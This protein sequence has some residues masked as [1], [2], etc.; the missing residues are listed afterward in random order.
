MSDQNSSD[1]QT[2]GN[3]NQL[4]VRS[5]PNVLAQPVQRIPRATTVS[6][7]RQDADLGPAFVLW[8][9]RQWWKITIPTGLVLAG[10]TAVV[11]MYF[12][13]PEYRASALIDIEQTVPFIAFDKGKVSG[14]RGNVQYIQTQIEL[15]RSAVVL[16]PVLSKPEIAKLEE[17][18]EQV[19]PLEYL[20]KQITVAQVGKSQLYSV[21]YVCPSAQAAADITNAV[22]T[23]YLEL[24]TDEEYRLSQRVIALLEEERLRRS[25]EVERLRDRVLELAKEVTGKDPFGGGIL[26]LSKNMGPAGNLYQSLTEVEVNREVLKAEIQ[27]L[28]DAPMLIPDHAKSSGLLDL[29]VANHPEVRQQQALLDEIRERMEGLKGMVVHLDTHSGYGR[30]LRNLE[31]ET[32]QLE[33]LKMMLRETLSNQNENTQAEDRKMV[34]ASMEQQLV[35]LNIKKKFLTSRFEKHLKDIQSGGAKSVQLEFSRAELKREEKVFE[36][37]AARKLA[38][39]TELRAPARVRLRKSANVPT[40]PLMPIPYKLLLV[41]CAAA[42]AAPL[43]LAIAREAMVRRVTDVEQLRQDSQLPILGEVARFPIR[44]VATGTHLLSNKM[45][46]EMFIF[47]ESVDSLRT[48]LVL[49]KR[50]ASKSVLAITSATS[51]EGKTSV[52]T[53]LTGS[54]A[55]ATKKPT[56]IIDAD[57]RSPDVANVLGTPLKPG[58]AEVLQGKCPLEEAIHQVGQ[59]NTYV[60]PAGRASTN[61]HHM[62]Q[63]PLIEQLLDRLKEDFETIVIDTPPILGASESLIFANAA[64]TVL[65]CSLRDI[66]RSK[67]VRIA[68][69]RL[70]N[71]GAKVAGAVLGGTP[72]NHYAY[73]YGHYAHEPS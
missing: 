10:V 51:G 11:I 6:A 47:A 58:L 9:L 68:V 7:S 45:Q 18:R 46:R 63:G 23:V 44:P 13:V 30:L 54:I 28:R 4:P 24:Q 37:I 56:V 15:L 2:L 61:P 59:S 64:D 69:D 66:S 70:E 31:E 53:S 35:Q 22:V 1:N 42:L 38:L 34:I 12:Y 16:S 50:M 20:Q 55:E 40:S 49:S 60:I 8:V 33:Q 52:A 71:A 36:L 67:Q 21:R 5:Q 39:Q 48:N 43:G 73:I 32:L 72:V 14:P 26:D 29:N 25:L 57:L 41:G 19:D 3:P 65:F 62:V 17:F 27:S